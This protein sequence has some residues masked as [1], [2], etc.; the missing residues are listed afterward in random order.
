[1]LKR[2]FLMFFIAG[3]IMVKN[4]QAQL[5]LETIHTFKLPCGLEVVLQKNNSAPV[6][7]IQF[8][9]K[10]GSA[11]ETNEEA[12][13]SHLIEHVLFKG[14]KSYKPG[15]IAKVIEGMGGSI[16]AFTTF[17][18]TIYYVV[19]PAA[20]WKV[21][22]KILADMV[23]NPLFPSKE[24][25]REKKVVLEEINRGKDSPFNI[26]S[27]SLF[28]S[29]YKV[30]PY[31]R[32]IIGYKATVNGLE[33]KDISNYFQKWYKPTNMVAV[34]VGDIKEEEVKK[35]LSNLFTNTHLSTS[36][37]QFPSEPP[38]TALR[39]LTLKKPFKETYLALS[40]PIPEFGT[41]DAY[42]LD[43]LSEVLG[44]G[45]GSRLAIAL[46]LK[47]PLVHSINTYAF[48]P[49]GPGLFITQAVLEAKN[50]KIVLKEIFTHIEDIKHDSI[51]TEELAKA[52]LNLE[53][54]FI[55]K[56]ETMEGWATTLGFFQVIEG[57]AKKVKDYLSEIKAIT[58]EDIKEVAQKY[59]MPEHLS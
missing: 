10:T 42:A 50:L 23:Q 20:Q 11:Y 22:L 52:K 28:A 48:T 54:A 13:I 59:L 35:T 39:L 32:P 14:T 19:M 29:A 26:L 49:K 7:A 34:I 37:P 45:E 17:D 57:E 8:W 58:K 36:S 51:S 16:N 1:M 44:R 4:A 53:S 38:Q 18:Y 27:E 40:F 9:I 6:V 46:K 5:P 30:Y 43:V 12:G 2:I 31:R 41:H 55:Y 33:Y 3:V 25:A 24:L 56:Q 21:G 15:E 47:K